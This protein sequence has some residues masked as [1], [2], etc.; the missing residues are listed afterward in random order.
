MAYK[1]INAVYYIADSKNDL[2]NLPEAPMGAEC[3]VIEEASEYKCTSD[4]R[5]FK[6]TGVA[7]QNGSVDL[8]GYATENYVNEAIA[9]IEELIAL[10]KE[11]IL[12]ICKS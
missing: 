8:T 3:F 6:Q 11:E 12:N 9:K 5:W 7:T 4:N 2:K 1:K 10:T